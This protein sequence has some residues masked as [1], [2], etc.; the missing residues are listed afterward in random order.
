[1]IAVASEDDETDADEKEKAINIEVPGDDRKRYVTVEIPMDQYECLLEIKDKH[2]LTWRGLLM[3]AQRELEY[4]NGPNGQYER[5]NAT[6]KRHGFTW[7]G[8]L[9]FAAKDLEGGKSRNPGSC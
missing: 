1:V 7:K 6:R 3:H 4:T 8:I 2:G 9:L 5:L